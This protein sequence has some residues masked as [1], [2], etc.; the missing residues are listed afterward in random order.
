MA[1]MAE[2]GRYTVRRGD[3][4]SSIALRQQRS[5]DALARA[6]GLADPDRIYAG[7]VLTIPDSD[8]TA[9]TGV[10]VVQPGDTLTKIAART[11]VPASTLIAANGI[12]N[13]DVVY[14]GGHLLLGVRNSAAVA[15]LA[16]CPV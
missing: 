16:R 1:G 15:P 13:P 12:V 4:L 3:T 10:V 11:G 6:N 2:T 14:V 9:A 8:S 5:I 7:Q